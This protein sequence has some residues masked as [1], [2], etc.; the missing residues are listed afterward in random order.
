MKKQISLLLLITIITAGSNGAI[1]QII[2]YEETIVKGTEHQ[3]W[4]REY[5]Y[6]NGTN[7]A[8]LPF[9]NSTYL[10][11]KVI[12]HPT[13]YNNI[14]DNTLF[15]YWYNDKILSDVYLD[16]LF[17]IFSLFG[18]Y[19]FIEPLKINGNNHIDEIFDTF[20]NTKDYYNNFGNYETDQA[21]A[22]ETDNS[23]CFE[24]GLT[25]DKN[26]THI[27]GM[28]YWVDYHKDTGVL[29][30]FQYRLVC[31]NAQ[32]NIVYAVHNLQLEY[33]GDFTLRT[34]LRSSSVSMGV[35]CIYLLTYLRKRKH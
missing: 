2:E 29:R 33:I 31:M 12:E 13:I 5:I 25:L 18:G 35:L 11:L 20:N 17:N 16:V 4:I 28:H 27:I 26:S 8:P 10:T 3:W 24:L 21:T 1:A 7:L 22:S 23:I 15:E 14:I 30:N 32:E 6:I 34:S 9:D 19:D